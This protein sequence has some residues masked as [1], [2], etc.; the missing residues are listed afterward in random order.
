MILAALALV[1]GLSNATPFG[2]SWERFKKYVE[3]SAEYVAIES[4]MALARVKQSLFRNK[5]PR[6]KVE[7]ASTTKAVQSLHPKQEWLVTSRR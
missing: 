4:H 7:K 2:E 1:A 3:P 5:T 6:L